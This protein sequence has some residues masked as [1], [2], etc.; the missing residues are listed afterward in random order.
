MPRSTARVLATATATA[1]LAL[2]LSAC[3]ALDG[4]QD[5]SAA[6]PAAHSTPESL[7][8]LGSC[9]TATVDRVIDGD[10]LDV[11]TDT[12]EIQRVRVLGIDTPET[13]HPDKVP[14]CMGEQASQTAGEL[15]APGASVTLVTDKWADE[16][17]RYDRQLAHVVV[18]EINL[19]AEM[20]ER[21]LAVTTSFDHSLQGQYQQTQ[22]TAEHNN[23]G[24]WGQC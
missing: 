12:G 6:T 22:D 21:G 20:L 5:V 9:E 7:C 17:D 15:A 11:A 16:F 1:A 23:L 10:T 14:E 13:V 4:A 18:G 3:S 24:L 19:G 2:G 8:D